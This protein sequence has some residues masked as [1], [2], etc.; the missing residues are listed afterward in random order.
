MN[1][2]VLQFWEYS[3]RDSG[4]VSNGCSL[5]LDE[6]EKNIFIDKIYKDRSSDNVPPEYDRIVGKSI[7]VFVSDVMVS[8]VKLNKSIRV[9]EHELNNLLSMAEI[10]IKDN[11]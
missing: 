2:V 10:I 4:V 1:K 3:I 7:D 11:E 5:H 6:G 8:R 9:Y